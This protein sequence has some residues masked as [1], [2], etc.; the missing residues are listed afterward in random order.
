MTKFK[1]ATFFMFFTVMN[2]WSQ[3]RVEYLRNFDKK[4]FH[5]GYYIG[6]NHTSLDV[7]TEEQYLPEDS[8]NSSFGF[9]VGLVG[10]YRLTNH[11]NLRFEP[12][13]FSSGKKGFIPEGSQEIIEWNS[14]YLRLPI[15]IKVST[16]RL[17]NL[18]PF[19]KGGVSYN[20][21][22]K[23]TPDDLSGLGYE[24][25]KSQFVAELGLGID[26]YLHYFKCSPSIKGIY[27][28][29]DEINRKSGT[30]AFDSF[31]TKGI[32]FSITFE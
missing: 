29:T 23:N 24:I 19:I 15:L 13:L 2:A 17:K 26:F 18:R 28:I 32:L 9:N 11:L 6:F 1:I 12:G 3:D 14:T 31:Q 21:N 16:E 7:K 22:F 5:W 30:P 10:D 25:N 8:T 20:Y 27:G 4:P